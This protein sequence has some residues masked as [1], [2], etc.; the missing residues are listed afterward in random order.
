MI[1]NSSSEPTIWFSHGYA[2]IRDAVTM[3]R[4][5]ARVGG[6]RVRLLASHPDADAAVLEAADEAFLEPRFDG[7]KDRLAW[8]LDTCRTHRVDLFVP[9]FGKA[10]L[11]PHAA[12]FA[13]VGTKLLIPA[14]ADT[15]TLLHDK[16]RFTA[17]AV[18]AGLPMPWTREVGDAAGFDEALDDLAA[19]GL[20][21]CVKPPQ[22]VFGAGFWRLDPGIS[23]FAALMDPDT[24]CLP[25]RV[26][27]AALTDAQGPTPLLV[28]EHLPGDEWS[29]DALCDQGR[30]IA[31]V[32]RRKTGR[33]QAIE[34]AGPALDI[35]RAA[36]ALFGLSGLVNLQC[37]A[38]GD[39]DADPR[40]L[41][42]NA[43]MS[44]GCLYTA[45][46][47]VNLPWWHVALALGLAQESDI[48]RPVG[49]ARVAAVAG[50]VRVEVPP[51]VSPRAIARAA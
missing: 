20:P 2:S 51:P 18:A 50:A 19:L 41:E 46:S 44:G 14:D 29:I 10:K 37:K 40:L 38:A 12:A 11:A 28:M 32:A 34:V 7:D 21:A 17:A 3:I 23:A 30:T 16:A 6:H 42:I 39:R 31:A 49:G 22:G 43:R 47:G 4:D 9:G 15:L 13:A 5:G 35:A 45:A 24:R 1:T 36:I 33:A 48:P 8:Y 27:R 26:M 25:P